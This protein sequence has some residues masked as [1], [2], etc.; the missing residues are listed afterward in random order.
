MADKFA[1]QVPLP[2]V[3]EGF[4]LQVKLPAMAELET[5]FGEFVFVDKLIFG[6]PRCSPKCLTAFL[7]HC[8]FDKKGEH[9]EA[10]WPIDAPL[11]KLAEKALDALAYALRGK[12]HAEWILSISE[13]E[14]AEN[15][16][17]GTEA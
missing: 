15:P 8:V 13:A 5:E 14:K 1:G 9:V 11:E 12:S 7:K 10:E 4:F 3:G 2:E 17:G 6:L 16:T